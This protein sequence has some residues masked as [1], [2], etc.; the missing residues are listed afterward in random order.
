MLKIRCGR[1]E[2]TSL[3]K[4]WPV[5]YALGVAGIAVIRNW[6]NGDE[7]AEE[8]ADELRSLANRFS[9]DSSLRFK[10]DIPDMDNG[11]RLSAVG[12]YV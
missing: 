5:H 12:R 7:T 8:C 10:L 3:P 2:G 9:E 4:I 11:E 1:R 6:M